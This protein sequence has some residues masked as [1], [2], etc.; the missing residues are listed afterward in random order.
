LGNIKNEERIYVLNSL[1]KSKVTKWDS[2]WLEENTE[3]FQRKSVKALII[4]WKGKFT[5]WV[6]RNP[7]SP[8]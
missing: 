7:Q 1:E 2:D 4:G 6:G 3:K 5:W 8:R